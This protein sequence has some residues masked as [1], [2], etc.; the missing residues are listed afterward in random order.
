MAAWSWT[1]ELALQSTYCPFRGTELSSQQLLRAAHSSRECDAS[2]LR[3]HCSHMHTPT[4]KHRHTAKR[5]QTHKNK[6]WLYTIAW[7]SSSPNWAS[8]AE[9]QAKPPEPS[10][11]I[12]LD[13]NLTGRD[14]DSSPA[15][16][17]PLSQC[18]P[19]ILLHT[20]FPAL[21]HCHQIKYKGGLLETVL[22]HAFQMASCLPQPDSTPV[23]PPFP[24]SRMNHSSHDAPPVLL[25]HSVTW[26]ET[27]W[28]CTVPTVCH[29]LG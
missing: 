11:D 4:Y 25:D 9:V 1:A 8:H 12:S 20:P 28:F 5:K 27:Q 16:S 17:S 2:G 29:L 19:A 10:T 24:C 22:P 7:V 14:V 13:P 15:A 21:P 18:H 3:E 6:Q 26:A 23:S